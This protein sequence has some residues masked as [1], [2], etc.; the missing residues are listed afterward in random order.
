MKSSCIAR[1]NFLISSDD[2]SGAARDVGLSGVVAVADGAS[3]RCLSS[4]LLSVSV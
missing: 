2:G 4:H 1:V 3:S